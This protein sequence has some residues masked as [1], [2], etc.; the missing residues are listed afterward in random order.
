MYTFSGKIFFQGAAGMVVKG[1]FQTHKAP[2]AF[3]VVGVLLADDTF[4]VSQDTAETFECDVILIPRK[5]MIDTEHG[6]RGSGLGHIVT[7]GFG[8]PSNYGKVIE[9]MEVERDASKS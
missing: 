2:N 1:D 4:P 5:R 9:Y 8:D 3:A 6:Y 7:D